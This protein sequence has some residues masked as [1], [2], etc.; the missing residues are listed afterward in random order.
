MAAVSNCSPLRYFVAIGRA[1]I[2]PAVLGEITIPTA[3]F[4]E[5]THPSAPESVREWMADMPAWLKI[6]TV[7]IP[8]DSHLAKVLDA[9][10]VEAIQLAIGRPDDF[11]LIDNAAGGVRPNCSV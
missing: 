3:V 1:D 4:H 10:E 11:I 7:R 9:G 8:M 5:L 2:L 6:E